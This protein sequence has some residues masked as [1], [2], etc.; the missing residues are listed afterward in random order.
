MKILILLLLA[1]G[2]RIIPLLLL[3]Q[4]SHSLWLHYRP[5]FIV[6]VHPPAVSN[7]L[8]I[9]KFSF[10][11]WAHNDLILISDYLYKIFWP[12]CERI[13]TKL[14]V[15]PITKISWLTKL[16]VC[17]CWSYL[18]LLHIR[19]A[20]KGAVPVYKILKSMFCSDTHNIWLILKI[21]TGFIEW[22]IR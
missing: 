1:I 21:F 16:W 17:A 6:I 2:L 15:L 19:L 22:T 18:H 7:T 20:A 14:H 11:I 13:V 4:H 3:V 5:N 8:I 9:W 12:T 10:I